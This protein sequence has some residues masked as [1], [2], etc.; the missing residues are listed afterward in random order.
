MHK[1]YIC[2][3]PVVTEKRQFDIPDCDIEDIYFTFNFNIQKIGSKDEITFTLDLNPSL[4]VNRNLSSPPE[5]PKIYKF[6]SNK[7]CL[8]NHTTTE[9]YYVKG[10]IRIVSF[11]NQIGQFDNNYKNF[12]FD[13]TTGFTGNS[14]YDIKGLFTLIVPHSSNLY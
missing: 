10:T 7:F 4:I 2:S 1:T 11:S 8:F 14:P 5:E 12:L 9:G 3:P 6:E 13:I